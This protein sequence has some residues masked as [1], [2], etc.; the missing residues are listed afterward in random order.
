MQ[1]EQSF[2]SPLLLLA[3]ELRTSPSRREP[4]NSPSR[5]TEM[6]QSAAA[7]KILWE[8]LP[9]VLLGAIVEASSNSL[10]AYLQLLSFSHV[11]RTSVRGTLHKFSCPSTDPLA[12]AIRPI[13]PPDAVAALVGPC[14]ALREFSFPLDEEWCEIIGE[15]ASAGGWVD[16]TFGGHTQLSIL[17]PIPAL[18]EPLVERVLSHL[19][20]LV[21]LT[22]EMPQMST[23]L[24]AALARSCPGLQRL[25]CSLDD[26]THLAALAPLS[27]VLKDLD[28][29]MANSKSLAAFVP[30]LSAVTSLKLPPCP[31]AALEPIAPHLTS[32]E[33]GGRSPEADL[34]GPW[35]C[36]LETLSLNLRAF[37]ARLTRLLAANQATLR[38]LSL[39]LETADAPSLAASLRAMPHLTHL[40][41]S[42]CEA[43]CSFSALLPP[44]LV[45]RLERLD[46]CIHARESVRITSS[47]LQHLR[48][49]FGARTGPASG[50]ALVCPALVDLEMNGPLISLRCPRLRT[51]KAPAQ[52]M[53]GA[54]PMP[55]LEAI[56]QCSS[57]SALQTEL[58]L[59][60]LTGSPR[61]RVLSGVRVAQ[62]QVL[63]RLCACQSL[64]RLEQLHLDVTRLPSPLVL[65][66]PGQLEHLDLLIESG[67]DYADDDVGDDDDDDE[68]PPLPPLDLQVEAPGLLV[69]SLSIENQSL[70]SVRV[71]LHNCPRLVRLG[72]HSPAALL[73]LQLDEN[74]EDGVVMQMQ[75]RCLSVE[76][77]SIFDAANLLGLLTRHG[78]RLRDI[79]LGVLR[80]AS[81]D[82][83]PQLMEAL[84]GLPRLAVLN[85]DVSG[86]PS[87]LS[88][89]C[90]QLRELDLYGLP[91]E[92][93]VVLACPLL[94]QLDG[95][96]DPSRQLELLRDS[97]FHLR[98]PTTSANLPQ[99]QTLHFAR[100]WQLSA[101]G[102]MKPVEMVSLNR[103]G[104]QQENLFG[105]KWNRR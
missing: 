10:V 60:L 82:V 63:A 62:P 42:V 77:E 44:D 83:W 47:R 95:I 54:V 75:P 92:A 33:L 101:S 39:V 34:P 69:F 73:S 99:T 2:D 98:A 4:L 97:E 14:K 84:S 56:K 21:E 80:V 64:V 9:P 20:G 43:S 89:A 22:V 71:R 55:D 100:C 49:L 24:L 96:G 32:F 18:P 19:P 11:V 29:R 7:Q 52:G 85:L 45:D 103:F 70:P 41:L 17:T 78:A 59:L 68:T 66:L 25:R 40:H 81:D 74:A 30:S 37:S 67:D 93:K 76:G 5:R 23:L 65:R 94:E 86:A 28:L 16:E 31:P 72:L 6:S 36:H 61:L 102:I 8:R 79:M 1:D 50:L 13:I 27:G 58:A 3:L 12:L 35:L 53:A 38:S 26:T 104:D 15:A 46:I 51:L 88:L 57:S 90:P 87:P 91:D 105:Q 48:F